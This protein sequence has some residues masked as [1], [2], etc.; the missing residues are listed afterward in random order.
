M[1]SEVFFSLVLSTASGL[2]IALCAGL[3]RSKCSHIKCCGIVDIER[4][5]KGEEEL[6]ASQFDLDTKKNNIN[7]NI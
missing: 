3:Y 7:P 6:D 4:D 5:V 1:P 2:M